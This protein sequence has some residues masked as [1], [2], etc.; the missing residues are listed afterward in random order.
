[1]ASTTRRIVVD[2]SSSDIVFYGNWAVDS[3]G[4]QDGVGNSGP[5]FQHTLHTVQE[6]FGFVHF[7]FEGEWLRSHFLRRMLI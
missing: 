1:M 5:T 2:D 7:I 3:R 6:D 4:S